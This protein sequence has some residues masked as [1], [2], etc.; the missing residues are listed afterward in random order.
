MERKRGRS[1]CPP[2]RGPAGRGREGA[3]RRGRAR[4]AG[5]ARRPRRKLPRSVTR[6]GSGEAWAGPSPPTPLRGQGKGARG[7]S[8]ASQGRPWR[9]RPP[10]PGRQPPP[11]RGRAGPGRAPLQQRPPPPPPPR[12]EPETLLLP[13]AHGSQPLLTGGRPPPPQVSRVRVAPR[14]AAGRREREPPRPPRGRLRAKWR[15][16]PETDTQ[17]EGGG[18]RDSAAA[19]PPSAPALR[20]HARPP[21]LGKRLA[22]CLPPPPAA[23]ERWQLPSCTAPPAE[24]H[25]SCSFRRL[26]GAWPGTAARGFPPGKEGRRLPA[27]PVAPGKPMWCGG[28]RLHPKS[29]SS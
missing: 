8:P 29:C 13:P 7:L 27:C 16:E 18:G 6:T 10:P 12:T 20:A 3:G 17:D 28:A 24:H 14:A 23:S 9:P 25:G 5:P 2:E 19:T 22:F 1:G 21:A 15:R 26:T 4:G 11:A